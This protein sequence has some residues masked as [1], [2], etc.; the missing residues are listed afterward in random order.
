MRAIDFV[1][2]YYP[3]A[4][5]VEIETGISAIAMLAQSAGESGWKKPRGNMFFG[6]KDIDGLNGN[7]QL[8]RTKEYHTS[9]NIEYPVVYSVTP[10]KKGNLIV[11]KYDV[12]TWFR[13]YDT[14]ADSFRDYAKFIF[15]NP[16]YEKALRVREIPELYLKQLA[17]AGYATG[18]NYEDYMMQMLR[19][20]VKRVR[21]L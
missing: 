15:E 5:K 12:E 17:R 1:R 2:T 13:K 19:S 9:S 18:L 3:E 10:V 16:R 7:E 8:I 6:I 11:Y 14:P 21:L 20:V 4:Q